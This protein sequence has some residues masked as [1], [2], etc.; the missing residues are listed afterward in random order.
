MG[1][2]GGSGGSAIG[3]GD[4]DGL[5]TRGMIFNNDEFINDE[6]YVDGDACMIYEVWMMILEQDE[7]AMIGTISTGYSVSSAF[8]Q[9]KTS[10]VTIKNSQFS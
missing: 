10:D 7:V 5:T 4:G 9:E 6:G 2:E 8:Q 3:V 1:G